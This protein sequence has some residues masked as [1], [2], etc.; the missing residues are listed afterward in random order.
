MRVTVRSP[1]PFVTPWPRELLVK[2]TSGPHHLRVRE[3]PARCAE[4][5]WASSLHNRTGE[6]PPFLHMGASPEQ[7]VAWHRDREVKCSKCTRTCG[8]SR[9][10]VW[11]DLPRS[12][13]PYG[14][15]RKLV[16]HSFVLTMLKTSEDL[17]GQL[18]R[19][20]IGKP[21]SGERDSL[22]REAMCLRTK[23]PTR[24]RSGIHCLKSS[25]E[26]RCRKLAGRS[27]MG[28]GTE[29]A[30]N[31]PPEHRIDASSSEKKHDVR[32]WCIEDAQ[33]ETRGGKRNTNIK[34]K[35]ITATA[36]VYVGR[37]VRGIDSP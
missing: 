15:K 16:A 5:M 37:Q 32:T 21:A 25:I 13:V 28:R 36:V 17:G 26:R 18:Q 33:I 6:A 22:E 23:G 27:T 20:P 11:V 1:P 2:S 14:Y 3:R 34:R 10:V 9:D 8:D 4:L 29:R 35:Y 31:N 30:Q 24:S 12:R 19:G 7:L